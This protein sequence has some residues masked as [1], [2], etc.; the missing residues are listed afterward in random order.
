MSQSHTVKN[1]KTK[2]LAKTKKSLVQFT[3]NT[4]IGDSRHPKNP[5]SSTWSNAVMYCFGA[6][7]A[8][9]VVGAF[10]ILFKWLDI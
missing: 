6:R 8:T 2:K 9:V 7:T 4:L 3:L 5:I 10:F 1:H